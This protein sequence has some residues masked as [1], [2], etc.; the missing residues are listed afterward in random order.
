MNGNTPP[1]SAPTRR[2]ARPLA[3]DF[4]SLFGD[5]AVV[6]W[7]IQLRW[8]MLGA[9]LGLGVL[10]TL[11]GALMAQ[12]YANVLLLALPVAGYNLVFLI[13]LHLAP[14]RRTTAL[15]TR[16]R[17]LQAPP[18]MIA[19]TVA[20]HLTGGATTPFSIFYVLFILTAVVFT[21]RY[22]TYVAAFEAALCYT[23]LVVLELT[24]WPP[25]ANSMLV[26]EQVAGQDWQFV[27]G[28]NLLT[29]LFILGAGA[30]MADRLSRRILTGEEI[31]QRQVG[32]L[33]LL[34]RF[35][36]NLSA[37]PNLEQ[38]LQY[39]VTELS[40]ILDAADCSL[41]LLNERN[42]AEIR[43][44]VG[45]PPQALIAYRKR[46]LDQSNPLLASLLSS[47]AGMFAPDIDQVSG[48]RDLVAPP[49]Q[50]FYSF[51]LRT[52]ERML[53]M[54][55][56]SFTRPY[57]MPPSTYDLV[58][59]CSRQASMAI[60]RTLL[61]QE[62]QRAAREM[63]SLYHIGLAASSSLEIN[64]VL[65]QIAD[66]VQ[67]LL[68]PD[69]LL[70]AFYDDT[71]HLLDF[72]LHRADGRIWPRE[73]LPVAQAGIAGWIVTHQQ[74]LLIRDWHTE[75][76]D[77]GLAPATCADVQSLV[78]VPL[79]T[80]NR[81]IGVLSIQK[82][83]PAAYGDDA[84]R[85]LS[86]IAAQAALALE[87]ARLHEA[88]REQALRD[89]LTGAY[90]HAA[91]LDNITRGVEHAAARGAPVAL[92]MLDIDLFKKYNDTYGHMAGDDALRTVVTAISQNIKSTDSVGRWG[93]E[94]FGV[95][96]PGA[97][98]A[99]ALQVAYRIRATLARIEMP[100][101]NGTRLPVPTVSQ[102]IACF[103]TDSQTSADLVDHAD[104]ALYR[105]KA[106]GRD[107]IIHWDQ[108]SAPVLTQQ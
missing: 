85:L 74:P 77:V 20:I 107:C 98:C 66:Q 106:R 67:T 34:Y 51:P 47:G 10:L 12:M 83:E 87:N 90:N 58:A 71:R 96:L 57:T 63:S 99:Q 23:A 26:P 25:P 86:A 105:A 80:N 13:L 39:I 15:L 8:W 54:I 82:R 17:W 65:S 79:L 78:G 61:Y 64:S 75:L 56:F 37:V 84:L 19:I 100:V 7:A 42:E 81:V 94:E 14:L 43:A 2:P 62:A 44:A 36:D 69:S 89:S 30:Y 55:N 31:I 53:G 68:A 6:R 5:A 33:T 35:G 59:A 70:L 49:A 24:V 60:E 102:G 91:L 52:E 103:P 38:A 50:S 3:P 97:A 40:A 48:L 93:G 21:P 27:Y 92:I 1:A 22:G 88:T 9:M 18:D 104:M 76:P 45:I 95:L 32:D 4:L 101:H 11:T 108:L 72:V 29:L 41:V 46:M 28:W 16:L 73:T